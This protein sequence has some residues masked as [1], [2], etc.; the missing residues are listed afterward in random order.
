M[1]VLPQALEVLY[2]RHCPVSQLFCQENYSGLYSRILG[3]FLWQTC[4]PDF[5]LNGGKSENCSV[6]IVAITRN[7]G[8]SFR[9][10]AVCENIRSMRKTYS[11]K[12]FFFLNY[13][14]SRLEISNSFSFRTSFFERN[15]RLSSPR[16]DTLLECQKQY[17]TN[18]K[19]PLGRKTRFGLN[20]PFY[21]LA[22]DK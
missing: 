8:F 1:I 11:N 12:N 16:T 17:F 3:F 10:Y 14:G 13:D 20:W 18:R 19:P 9:C 22:D 5:T 6:F 7:F 15:Y 21:R 4:S 2:S